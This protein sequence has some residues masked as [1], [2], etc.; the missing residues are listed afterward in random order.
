MDGGERRFGSIAHGLSPFGSNSRRFPNNSM[1]E[2]C[3]IA[4]EYNQGTDH[5]MLQTRRISDTNDT[6]L[7]G[8]RTQIDP[9][10][11]KRN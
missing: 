6:E 11:R 2:H 10:V 8:R 5:S 9:K 1:I 7:N 4:P 3:G